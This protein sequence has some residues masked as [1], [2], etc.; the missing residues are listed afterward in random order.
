MLTPEELEARAIAHRKLGPL[1]S[2]G[3][4]GGRIAEGH[5]LRVLFRQGRVFDDLV[6]FQAHSEARSGVG[7]PVGG[8]Y[9]ILSSKS[10]PIGSEWGPV[11]VEDRVLPG[12][13]EDPVGWVDAVTANLKFLD[14]MLSPGVR[15]LMGDEEFWALIGVL[16]GTIDDESSGELLAALEQLSRKA[17]IQFNDTLAQRLHE[18]DHPENTV[19]SSIGG[20]SMVSADASLYYRCEIIAAGR[21]AFLDRIARPGPGGEDAGGS[22]EALLEL[23]DAASEHDLPNPQVPIETGH[24]KEFW[25]DAPD[26]VPDPASA[27]PSPGPFS[28]DVQMARLRLTDAPP[29]FFV[30]WIAYAT[31]TGG[32]VREIMGCMMQGTISAARAEVVPFVTA[33]LNDG[34]VLH[35]NVIV[36]RMG[37]DG[38]TTGVRLVGTTRRSTLS[39]N[40]YIDTYYNGTLPPPKPRG[41]R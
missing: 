12:R 19:R 41:R 4:F 38:V 33:L 37:V 29:L 35:T 11:V 21:D 28:Y 14:W 9:E 22:G 17:L 25:S 27:I 30:G 31:T 15:P 23:V 18:L 16:G 7:A 34:E 36:Y 6:L 40:E 32:V 20:D 24:N 26:S 13:Q 10:F 2:H 1:R 5:A 8:E 3:F 39:L